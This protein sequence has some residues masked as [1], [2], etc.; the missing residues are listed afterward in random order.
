MRSCPITSLMG[1]RPLTRP[2][3]CC[4][5]SS[6]YGLLTPSAVCSSHLAQCSLGEAPWAFR[7][8]AYCCILVVAFLLGIQ[9]LSKMTSRGDQWHLVDNSS[10]PQLLSQASISSLPACLY[11]NKVEHRK[12]L[13]QSVTSRL[14]QPTSLSTDCYCSTALHTQLAKLCHQPCLV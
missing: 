6:W 7:R 4:R 12:I 3:T 14:L 8:S 2:W 5:T 1:R 13:L 11:H 9:G 10:A